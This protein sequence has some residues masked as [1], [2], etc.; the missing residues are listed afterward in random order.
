MSIHEKEEALFTEWRK[1]REDFRPDGAVDEQKYL[2]SEPKLLFILKKVNDKNKVEWDLR[3]GLAEAFRGQTWDLVVKWIHGIRAL[4]GDLDWATAGQKMTK[5]KKAEH[6]QT[7]A[8]MNLK[9]CPG[10]HNQHKNIF[11]DS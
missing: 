1:A 9:K 4:P 6:L 7:I 8:A 10:G 5:E 11:D 2:S 3:I